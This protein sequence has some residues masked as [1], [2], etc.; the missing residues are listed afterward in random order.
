MLGLQRGTVKL[1]SE[2]AEWARLFELEK[3]LLLET[4]GDR[5]IAVEHIGSTAIPDVP[6]KPIIDINVAVPSLADLNIEEFV[7]PLKKLGYYY[8]KDEKYEHRHL[9]VKGPE[10]KRTHHLN[11]VGMNSSRGW[12]R[13]LLFRNYLRRNKSAREEYASLKLKLEKQ[14]KE[15]RR[16][17]TE[18]KKKFIDNIVELAAVEIPTA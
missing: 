18:G 13:P 16:S 6:A 5:I 4:L 1:T 12:L 15:D 10:E 7:A 9:F 14:F 11:L 8:K 17:Y 3:Q 2:H